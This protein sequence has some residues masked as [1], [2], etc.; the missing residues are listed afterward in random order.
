MKLYAGCNKKVDNN[1]SIN[2]HFLTN[3]IP[4]TVFFDD[5]SNKENL[6]TRLI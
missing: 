3:W 6:W 4:E 5:V 2:M 1:P